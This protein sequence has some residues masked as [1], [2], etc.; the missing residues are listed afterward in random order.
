MTMKPY[1]NAAPAPFIDPVPGAVMKA[2]Q[3]H[4]DD[5]SH[6]HYCVV[7][8]VNRVTVIV[9][10]AGMG[11]R[12]LYSTRGEEEKKVFQKKKYH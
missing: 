11:Y 8:D 4:I 9:D 6:R 2:R 5:P 1:K 10:L 7:Q 3:M 12:T